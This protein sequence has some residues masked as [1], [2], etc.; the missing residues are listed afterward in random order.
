MILD[1]RPPKVFAPLWKSKRRYLCAWG[2]RGSGKSWDRAMHMIVRHLTEPGLSSI[3][4]RDVQKS[5]DQSV[6]KLLVETAARL[7][8]AADRPG[9]RV[10]CGP[11]SPRRS[12]GRCAFGWFVV[13]A[14]VCSA[15]RSASIQ[16][17]RFP[18]ALRALVPVRWAG[19]CRCWRSVLA[20]IL[21][22]ADGWCGLCLPLGAAW[23]RSACC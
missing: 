13:S 23:P 20:A 21:R 8:G 14:G 15:R 7:G 12:A 2:G 19:F 6:F 9:R 11:V 18:F 10:A 1:V 17:A 16:L 22:G 4:L 3:C 5:L